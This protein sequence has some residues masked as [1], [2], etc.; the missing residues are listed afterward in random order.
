MDE[1]CGREIIVE[2]FF[3]E[4]NFRHM[5][6]QTFELTH[7]QCIVHCPV[8]LSNDSKCHMCRGKLERPRIVDRGWMLTLNLGGY[9]Q[10]ILV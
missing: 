9:G 3:R 10:L 5:K 6:F 7:M 8:R 1:A 2:R 4:K